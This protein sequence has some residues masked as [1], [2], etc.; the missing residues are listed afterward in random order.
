VELPSW[1]RLRSKGVELRVRLAPRS[2]RNRV[3]GTYGDRL[4]IHLTAPPVGG[5][6][7]AALE[8]FLARAAGRPAGAAHVVFGHKDR[9]KIVLI[10][11]D[12]PEATA[13]R[14]LAEL[15]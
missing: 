14:L 13:S 15:T 4:K 3:S 6:A 7:N 10:E 2:S 12:E 8:S 11:C 5:A 1:M 9:S